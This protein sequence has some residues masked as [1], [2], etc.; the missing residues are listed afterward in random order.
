MHQTKCELIMRNGLKCMGCC[1]EFPLK[2]LQW[3]HLKPKYV[4]KANHEQQD[5]SY[6]NGS[7]LCRKC[8]AEIHKYLWWDDVFQTMTSIIE[9]NKK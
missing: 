9:G 3:H 5:D 2:D 8:H 7:L 4:S 1:K 6:S